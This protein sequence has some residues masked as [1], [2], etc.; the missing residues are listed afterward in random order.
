MAQ[1]QPR[2]AQE[3]VDLR[4]KMIQSMRIQSH[5]F[6]NAIELLRM[7]GVPEKSLEHLRLTI[8]FDFAVANSRDRSTGKTHFTVECRL[9]EP[10][11]N[12]PQPGLVP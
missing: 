11:T 3:Q 9:L 10:E 7:R 5:F 8:R 2:L 4:G 12:L 1:K 6:R